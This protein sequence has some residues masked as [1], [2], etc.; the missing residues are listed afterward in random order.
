MPILDN[1]AEFIADLSFDRLPAKTIEK[2]ELHV[3]DSFGA[4][5]A[6]ASSDDARAIC[7]LVKKMVPVDGSRDIPVAGFGFSAPMT[8]A[9]VITS[10]SARMTEI[11]DIHLLS[12]TTPGS[13]IV[14][15]ALSAAYVAREKG[16]RFFEGILAGYDVI[17]R[18]GTAV[19]GPVILYRGMWP[20]YLFGAIGAAAVGS[21]VFGLNKKQIKNALAIALT[22]SAGL[23]GKIPAGLTSRWLTLGSA[24]QNGLTASL[25]AEAGFSGDSAILDG[26][27][28]SI[29]GLD[30]DTRVLLD[31]LGENWKIEEMSLKPYCTARQALSPIEAFRRLLDTH[32]ID[33]ELI[34]E[35]QVTIPQQYSQMI[36]HPSFPESRMPSIVS[37]QYQMAL[38]AFYEEGLYDIQRKDMRDDDRI[39][40][41][42]KKVQVT[43][44]PDYTSL[45]P[46]QWPGKIMLKT[47]KNVFEAEILD[48]LGSPEQPMGWIDVEQKIKRVTAGVLDPSQIENLSAEVKGL[49]SCQTL[50]AFINN[51]PGISPSD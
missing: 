51:I 26:P 49:R 44:S 33:P 23:A 50:D 1:L 34:K 42:I 17:T 37:V 5:L 47:G 27:F 2:T 12:C 19:K 43:T 35:I 13:I 10:L 6:G 8:Y 24:L 36:N 32:Q 45:F 11:D 21:K 46:G 18:L 48:P 15:T 22:M 25:A 14:P 31:G 29:Y 4:M 30:L 40:N 20:T 16:E 39:R 28:P 38:A 9:T 3:F 7:D 41:F